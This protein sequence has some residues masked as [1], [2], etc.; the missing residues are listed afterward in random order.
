MAPAARQQQPSM[1]AVARKMP[2]HAA[3][4]TWR[5]ADG[6]TNWRAAVL[7]T[8]ENPRPQLG[9]IHKFSWSTPRRVSDVGCSYC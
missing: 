6:K 1:K 3:T 4:L 5:S 8:G 9:I 2:P 7:R